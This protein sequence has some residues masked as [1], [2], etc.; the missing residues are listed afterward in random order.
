MGV[1]YT[2]CGYFGWIVLKAVLFVLASFVFSI[3]FWA[4]QHW[5]HRPAKKKKK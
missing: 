1:G 4:T 3:I 5:L 2:K